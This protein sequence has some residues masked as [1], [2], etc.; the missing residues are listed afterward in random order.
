MNTE[1]AIV[2]L[3]ATAVR[4]FPQGDESAF[5]GWLDRLAFVERYEGRGRILSIFVNSAAADQDGLREM[6]ALFH[7]YGIEL[8]Q[9]AIFDRDEFADWL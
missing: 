2:R 3:E 9:L 7:R 6:L 8:R 5:F 4:F 1:P